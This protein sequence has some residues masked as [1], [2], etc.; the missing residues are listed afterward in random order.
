MGGVEPC[1]A[2][3][4]R[5]TH[6]TRLSPFRTET[7]WPSTRIWATL[8]G[9]PSNDKEILV[10]S[11]TSSTRQDFSPARPV[12]VDFTTASLAVQQRYRLSHDFPPNIFHSSALAT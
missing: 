9:R 10:A 8:Y 12:P 3:R 11:R 1:L 2:G 7:M 4:S 6:S 5:T